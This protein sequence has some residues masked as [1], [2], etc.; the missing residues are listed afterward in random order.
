MANP[1]TK[2]PGGKRQLIPELSARVPEK[3]NT[4]HESFV[5]G[6][7]LF[8]WLQAQGRITNAV[9]SDSNEKLI[10]AYCGVRDNV[11]AV[12]VALHKMKTDRESF[13]SYRTQGPS[14]ADVEF[15]AW[16]IYIT[17]CCFNGLF[18][19]NKKG[20]CNSPYGTPKDDIVNEVA[21]R[22][23]SK[24]LQGVEILCE[25]FN[26]A[27]R[28]EAGDFIYFDPPYWPKSKTASFTSYTAKGFKAGEQERLRDLARDLRGRGVHVLLSNS[29]VDETRA[30]YDGF[31]V[32]TVGARRAINS[33]A[34]RR[35]RVNELL[36]R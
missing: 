1:F 19:E 23:S 36:I 21:L 30:L 16:W 22:E 12:I 26:N 11:D 5:G 13:Y 15:A 18:R 9:L 6:G 31:D 25:D 28:A 24:A 4:Y 27:E 34:E 8:F 35:G 10:R 20:A 2:S 17:S 3:F 29:D 14:G 32:A 33:R 7:A